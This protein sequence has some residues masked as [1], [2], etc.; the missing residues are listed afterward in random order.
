MGLFQTEQFSQSAG[1]FQTN[2]SGL[3]VHLRQVILKDL[4]SG[5]KEGGLSELKVGIIQRKK[6]MAKANKRPLKS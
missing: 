3:E 5:K 1:S 6:G 2:L 4:V